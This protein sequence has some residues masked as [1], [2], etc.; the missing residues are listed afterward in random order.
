MRD[1]CIYCDS[2][3]DIIRGRDSF[4]GYCY[5]PKCDKFYYQFLNDGAKIAVDFDELGPSLRKHLNELR[6]K[7]NNSLK[8]QTKW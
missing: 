8:Y 5:C 6:T 2:T 1:Q 4:R 7:Y 3:T